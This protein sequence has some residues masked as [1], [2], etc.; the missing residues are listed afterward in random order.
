MDKKLNNAES[1]LA[2]DLQASNTTQVVVKTGE[3]TLFGSDFPLDVTVEQYTWTG[4][5]AVVTK[6]ENIT[7]SWRSGDV[8]TI[9]SRASQVCVQDESQDPKTRTQNA[10]SFLS[11]DRIYIPSQTEK[12]S[13]DL[14]AALDDIETNKLDKSVYDSEK[15]VMDVST[16]SGWTT[17]QYNDASITGYSE[18]RTYRVKAD[19]DNTGACTFEINS[20]W[21]LPV[22][23]LQGTE[24]L[25]AWEWKENWIAT[26]VYNSSL[27]VFQFSGQEASVIIPD[28][29]NIKKIFIAWESISI[30]DALY[31][32]SSDWKVYKTDETDTNK[33]W[34]IW[35]ATSNVSV[36]ENINIILTWIENNKTWLN[37]WQDYYLSWTLSTQTQ[38]QPFSFATFWPSNLT[39]N[40][41]TMQWSTNWS[42]QNVNYFLTVP[43]WTTFVCD[44]Y[45]WWF[46]WTLIWTSSNSYNSVWS[47]D[48]ASFNFSWISI[49]SNTTYFMD[50]RITSSNWQNWDVHR[51]SWNN[52]PNWTAYINWSAQSVDL[53]F[54]ATISNNWTWPWTITNDDSSLS[55]TVKVWTSI[56]STEL[57]VRKNFEDIIWNISTNATTWSILLWNAVWYITLNINWIPKKIPYYDI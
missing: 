57:E 14:Q 15:N 49:K 18:T 6:R 53:Y 52:Y 9:D 1:T 34:F 43:V 10:L 50:L 51:N 20:L 12:D 8:L 47:K 44:V 46:W 42:L 16:A 11:G 40:W 23:N 19:V 37:I 45:E 25:T 38:E 54:S 7:I 48:L 26:L 36:D 22:R 28:I 21:A 56:S 55:N 13:N 31:Q 24:D 5:T 35:F 3:G 17:Y 27:N 30:W 29:E 4:V 33:I 39:W 32:N 41:Q 2:A